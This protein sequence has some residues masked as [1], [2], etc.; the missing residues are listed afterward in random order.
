L[1]EEL[2]SQNLPINHPVDKH[3]RQICIFDQ[4][5]IKEEEKCVFNA[6]R[7]PGRFQNVKGELASSKRFVCLILQ[8][9]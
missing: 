3:K 5:K 9:L 6:S 4:N 1:G 7:I 2:S 8:F